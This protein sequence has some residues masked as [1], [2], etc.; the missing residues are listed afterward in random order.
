MERDLRRVV[1]VGRPRYQPLPGLPDRL[2]DDRGLRDRHR[3]R[4]RRPRAVRARRD[5]L[6]YRQHLGLYRHRHRR[7]SHHTDHRGG[8][9]PH[10]RAHPDRHG[11]SRVHDPGRLLGRRA[12]RGPASPPRN[13]PGHQRLA[14]PVGD[15]REG[16]CRS[17]AAHRGLRLQ[18]L[19]RHGVRQRGS[20]APPRQSRP[21]RPLGRGTADCPVHAGPGRPAGRGIPG[22]AAVARL[23]G[24]GLRRPGPWAAAAGPRSWPCPSRCR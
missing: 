16:Q 4:G 14:E 7:D 19:G 5:R 1:R 24:A 10:Y 11:G 9:H 12:A 18:R 17:R 23:A 6:R 20:E 21:G 8:R 3:G 15:R 2:A 22:H 13:L